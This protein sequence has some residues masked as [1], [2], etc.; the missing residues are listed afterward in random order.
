MK[1]FASLLL[2]M[3][4]AASAQPARISFVAPLSGVWGWMGTM[5]VQGARLAAD[6][7]LQRGTRI[8]LVVHDDSCA[9]Q[10]TYEKLRQSV[11]QDRPL[12]IIGAG[13]L[14]SGTDLR[15]MND[16]VPALMWL[17]SS[18]NDTAGKTLSR[19]FQ[20]GPP[21]AVAQR[22]AS[23]FAKAT[24]RSVDGGS[25]CL[26][27]LRF[28]VATT[29]NDAAICPLLS[30][31]ERNWTVFAKSYR[32]KF[33]QEP[34]AHALVGYTAARIAIEAVERSR[35]DAGRFLR[36]LQTGEFAT[37]FGAVKPSKPNPLNTVFV[38]VASPRASSDT[39]KSMIAAADK[40][41]CDKCNKGASEC[42]QGQLSAPILATKE[43]DC[44]KKSECPQGSMLQFR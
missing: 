41:S 36:E 18:S 28:D 43:G 22:M 4:L 25:V 21:R 30:A 20:L 13:C 42:P 10:L 15:S 31:D 16:L 29:D 24:K 23:D 2:W 1:Y 34:D 7:A 11:E 33:Q 5:Q 19:V 27:A 17:S 3:S 14:P 38:A 39:L 40:K 37:P 9:P 32:A 44:C 35:G 8:D 12:A 6:E 26:R